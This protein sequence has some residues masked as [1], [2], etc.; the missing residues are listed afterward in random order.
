MCNSPIEI[1]LFQ[2]GFNSKFGK[3]AL[4]EQGIQNASLLI[5]SQNKYLF[6]NFRCRSKRINPF[7]M[8]NLYF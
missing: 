7:D 4:C 1:C 5:F 3:Y 6:A 8:N 2:T